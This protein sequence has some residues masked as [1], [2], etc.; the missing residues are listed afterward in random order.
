MN[1]SITSLTL[2]TKFMRSDITSFQ[3]RV[4]GLEQHMGS[5]EVQ[6]TMS[7]D[8]DHNLL[9][10]SSKLT[11]ME[12]RSWRDNICLHGI[13]ENEEGSD[14]QAFLSSTL[15]KLTSLDFSPSIE[16]QGAH[17]IGPKRSDNSARPRPIIACLLRHNQTCQ[18]LKWCA[19]MARSG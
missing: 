16:F 12:D 18:I 11:D 3:S 7:R 5:L 4:K 10:L 14:V 19:I 6:A 15:P 2:E 17:R 1:A 9:Y 13:P 8:R